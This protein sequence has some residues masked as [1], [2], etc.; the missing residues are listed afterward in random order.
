MSPVPVVGLHSR[1]RPSRSSRSSSSSYA[2]RNSTCAAPS[3][4]TLSRRS[5]G[6]RCVSVVPPSDVYPRSYSGQYGIPSRRM[7]CCHQ[8]RAA[9]GAGAHRPNVHVVPVDHRVHAHE[10][11]P[12]VVR[13]VEVRQARAVR[14][15]AARAHEHGA[16]ARPRAQVRR[17]RGLHARRLAREGERVGGAGGAHEGL[18]LRERVGRLDVDAL[19]LA[20]RVRGR[21]GVAGGAAERGEVEDQQHEAILAA[22]EGY[23]ERGQTAKRQPSRL[24]SRSHRGAPRNP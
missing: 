13:L 17:E 3:P 5:A 9:Q 19:E 7:N 16:H 18:D 10:A 20:R 15:R 4:D 24:A 6:L 12:A 23:R 14:V 21:G 11:R 2:G 8:S 1:S 22:V